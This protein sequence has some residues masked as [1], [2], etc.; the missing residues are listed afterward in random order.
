MFLNF[1][2]LKKILNA[3]YVAADLTEPCCMTRCTFKC[4]EK[5]Q[6]EDGIKTLLRWRSKYYGLK[7][8]QQQ[9][10][11]VELIQ[12][13]KLTQLNSPRTSK[14]NVHIVDGI[15]VCR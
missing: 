10:Y 13:T 2:D 4:N 1:S 8:Q 6:T 11:L 3:D 15:F 9:L 14:E 5:F 12:M 7:G